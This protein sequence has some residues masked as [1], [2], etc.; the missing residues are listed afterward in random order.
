MCGRKFSSKG[1]GGDE[2]LI[3]FEDGAADEWTRLAALR[4]PCDEEEAGA[5]PTRFESNK[6]FL[7]QLQPGD[8][9]WAPWTVEA[10]FAGTVQTIHNGEAHIHFDDGDQGWVQLQQ[11]LPLT[12]VVGM[13]VMG[14]WQMGAGYFPGT[15]TKVEQ[16][17]IFITYD[18]GDKEWTRPAALALPRSP[19]GPAARPTKTVSG[20]IGQQWRWLAPIAIGLVLLF[21]RI[22]CRSMN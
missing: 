1:A 17:R 22:G 9:V 7:D 12:L 8:R 10:L 19:D 13:R 14:R 20:G 5:E 6:R 18:D 21:L 11:L 16:E 4:I 15:I 2:V 3:Q